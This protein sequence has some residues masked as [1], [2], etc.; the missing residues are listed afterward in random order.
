MSCTRNNLQFLFATQPRQR[1][2]VELDH[3]VIAPAHN[4]KGRSLNERSGV[5]SQIW[6]PA[7]RHHC[8][9]HATELRRRNQC[10][11]ATGT[12]SE[13]TGSQMI[14]PAL[15]PLGCCN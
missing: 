7:A 14:E 1:R 6:S 4:Q 11:S 5:T 10:G 13:I 8:L 12:G 9:N 2:F 15:D 3:W